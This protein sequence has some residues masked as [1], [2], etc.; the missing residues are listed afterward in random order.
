MNKPSV[1][2]DTLT[3]LETIEMN[4][5]VEE[6]MRRHRFTEADLSYGE[7][8]GERQLLLSRKAYNYIMSH[9]PVQEEIREAMKAAPIKAL[10]TGLKIIELQ[11]LGGKV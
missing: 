3:R 8:D 4:K 2:L 5:A 6:V 10:E 11:K 9:D 7:V 1:S